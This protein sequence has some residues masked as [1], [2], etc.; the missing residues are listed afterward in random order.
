[1]WMSFTLTSRRH[2]IHKY[3]AQGPRELKPA[4]SWPITSASS[5][6]KLCRRGTSLAL[7]WLQWTSTS[8]S[9]CRDVSW[10]DTGGNNPRMGHWM[11]PP[12]HMLL[13][14][15][16]DWHQCDF[17]GLVAQLG[18]LDLPRMGRGKQQPSFGALMG[19]PPVWHGCEAPTLMLPC[20][21]TQAVLRVHSCILIVH[22]KAQIHW[23]QHIK[24]QKNPNENKVK[25][26]I[27][28]ET[29]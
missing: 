8:Q 27:T 4:L 2:P 6:W 17:G 1:M 22:I 29:R 23:S 24:K 10:M 3:L 26:V 28:K 11:S 18:G 16:S 19:T 20:T 12:N 7:T 15:F 5:N 14:P 9:D 21:N 13:S 25:N